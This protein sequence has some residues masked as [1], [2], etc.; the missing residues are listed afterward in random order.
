MRIKFCLTKIYIRKM[1][2]R[3]D[4]TTILRVNQNY[5]MNS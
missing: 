1:P 4:N 2:V 3:R 5:L